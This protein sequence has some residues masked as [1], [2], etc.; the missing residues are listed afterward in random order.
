MVSSILL[1]PRYEKRYYYNDIALLRLEQPVQFNDYVMPVCLPTR[2][3]AFLKDSDLEGR[4]VT[5]MGWGD[6]EFGGRSSHVLRE[7]TF[8]V[9]SRKSCNASYVRVASNRFP[10]GITQEMLCA[11]SPKG[12]MDACQGDSGGPL[13]ALENGRYTQVG[14][15][16]FGYKCGDKEFPGVYTKV[17]YYV[18]WITENTQQ[19]RT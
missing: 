5:V 8:P 10:R 18:G 9:V 2:N 12:G 7:A 16:S 6:D 4:R 15:V 11:G 13:L 19:L 17:A 1:H 14:I 3:S